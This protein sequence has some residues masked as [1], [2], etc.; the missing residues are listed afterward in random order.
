MEKI[1]IVTPKGHKLVETIKD[2]VKHISF[3]PIT[4]QPTAEECWE[5]VVKNYLQNETLYRIQEHCYIQEHLCCT[6][7][8]PSSNMNV[9]LSKE[10]AEAFIYL[11]ALV[12]ARDYY[13]KGWIPNC[14]D[15]GIKHCIKIHKGEVELSFAFQDQKV[16]S[17]KTEEIRNKFYN[18][19][20]EWIEK[21]KEL[22]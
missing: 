1:E 12:T 5:G 17:F 4:T 7:M 14:E 16:L 15:D 22:I 19:F 13:N 9:H 20:K 18:D 21:A 8:H 11:Q 6:T 10:R 3:E 2:G